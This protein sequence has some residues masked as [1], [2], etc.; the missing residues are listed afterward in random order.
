MDYSD[1]RIYLEY[2]LP[3]RIIVN[4]IAIFRDLD[5][6]ESIMR[7]TCTMSRWIDPNR[8]WQLTAEQVLPINNHPIITSLLEERSKLKQGL[9]SLKYLEY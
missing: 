6:Q 5:P 2:Y 4:T 1:I 3:R 7:S 8:P 9:A